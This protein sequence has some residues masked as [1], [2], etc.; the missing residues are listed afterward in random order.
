MNALIW[1][2]HQWARRM[3]R[4]GLAAVSMLLMAVLIQFAYTRPLR[5]ETQALEAQVTTL[6]LAMKRNAVRP[7]TVVPPS[8]F[9]DNLPDTSVAAGVIGQLEQLAHVHGLQ[10]LRGQYAQTAVSGT[11]LLR[12][13]VS[14]PVKAEYPKIIAFAATSLQALPSLALDEFR[15]KRDSIETATLEAD[16]RFN[17]YLREAAR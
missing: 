15:F 14:L 13:Q 7:V 8:G 4:T 2:A 17:L 12:W 3:G 6:Q 10:L 9:T 16:L 1:H 11:S 5:N